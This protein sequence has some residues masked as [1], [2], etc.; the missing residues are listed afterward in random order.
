MV[1]RNLSG[2]DPAL[3]GHPE[4]FR[5]ERPSGASKRRVPQASS[6]GK[7]DQSMPVSDMHE[8][9]LH[10]LGDVYDAEHRFLEDRREREQSAT[11]HA[12]KDALQESR[13]SAQRS[14]QNIEEA[15]EQLGQ[16][17]A[18][19]ECAASK[20]LIEEAQE[21]IGEAQ[22]GAVR[23][24]LINVAIVKEELYKVAGYRNLLGAVRLLEQEAGVPIEGRDEI[25]RVLEEN[26]RATERTAQEAEQR[27]GELFDVAKK[28]A[29]FQRVRQSQGEQEKGLLEKAKDKLSGQ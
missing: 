3:R 4:S 16:Q 1:H 24:C 21:G 27:A 6:R 29:A 11:S 14:I 10:E 23:D 19:Q 15:F 26:L 28:T 13:E 17:P 12:L 22:N 8:V 7:E 9:F 2:V 20:G 25:A 5:T 18:R